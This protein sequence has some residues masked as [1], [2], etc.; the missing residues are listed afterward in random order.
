MN[1]TKEQKTAIEKVKTV[2]ADYIKSSKTFDVLYSKKLGYIL[3][4]GISQN[5]D[6]LGMEPTILEDGEELCDQILYEI[7]CDILEEHGY[8]GDIYLASE[9]NK[10]LIRN[11]YQPYMTQL[12]E[13]Q[14]LIE[15]QFTNPDD[16]D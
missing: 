12:P 11:A 1:Y 14:D 2:F 15:K 10:Q 5:M 4:T 9:D 13:Y 8:H 16:N 3:L 6:N 7:A